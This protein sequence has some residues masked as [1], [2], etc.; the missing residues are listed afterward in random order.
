MENEIRPSPCPLLCKLGK[1]RG[2]NTLEINI[3]PYHLTQIQFKS[4]ASGHGFGGLRVVIIQ[5]VV[6]ELRQSFELIIL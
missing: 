1:V 5:F 6:C 4:H 3:N 2:K